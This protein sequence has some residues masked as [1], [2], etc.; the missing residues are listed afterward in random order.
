MACFGLALLAVLPCL[1]LRRVTVEYPPLGRL[2]LHKALGAKMDARVGD[3]LDAQ[4]AQ[5]LQESPG[6]RRAALRVA[7]IHADAEPV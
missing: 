7:R 1:L 6:L 5:R 3:L 2:L 4:A